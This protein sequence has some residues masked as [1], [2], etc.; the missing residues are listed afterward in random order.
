MSTFEQLIEKLVTIKTDLEAIDLTKEKDIA[1]IES[2]GKKPI[3]GIDSVVVDK[4]FTEEHLE[5]T[6]DMFK[7][8]NDR[9]GEYDKK[10]DIEAGKKAQGDP[11]KLKEISDRIK[12]RQAV[13]EAIQGK[14]SELSM[15]KAVMDKYIVK[16]DHTHLVERQNR[17]K[18]ANKKKIS[19]NQVKLS[20]IADFKNQVSGELGVIQTNLALIEELNQ[21]RKLAKD[22]ETREANLNNARNQ[23][24][25]PDLIKGLEDDLKQ[26]K[27]NLKAK[28]AE[29]T[30]KHKGVTLDPN[31]LVN[32]INNAENTANDTIT[33][34]KEKIKG[35]AQASDKDYIKIEISEKL[36]ETFSDNKAFVKVLDATTKELDAENITL[37]LENNKIAENVGQIELGTKLKENPTRGINHSEITDEDIQAKID[38]DSSIQALIPALSDKEKKQEVYKSLI[39]GAKYKSK[40]LHP[41]AAFK[42]RFSKK[43]MEEWENVTYKDEM[44]Q[45]AR[46]AIE[47]ERKAEAE[48]NTKAVKLATSKE[49]AFRK[50]LFAHIMGS[51]KAEVE[52]MNKDA[53]KNPGAVL[54]EAYAQV[55][56]DDEPTN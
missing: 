2:M 53:D 51:T 24:Y 22:I 20:Q 25:D 4:G 49:E 36:D 40:L 52:Q 8:A 39:E 17:K 11:T 18:D 50:G 45:R 38:S 3:T 28:T 46:E 33:T 9:V 23:G 54:A 32:S 34:M 12:A 37:G 55:Q 10:Q 13:K 15:K 41:I 48:T 14:Y 31:D 27:T 29:I 6:I 7:I 26:S 30:K 1:K 42:A 47:A 19:D 16:Y 44:K 35:K 5:A 43:T 56:D 21:L